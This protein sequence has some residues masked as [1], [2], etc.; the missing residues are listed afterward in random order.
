MQ[1]PELKHYLTLIELAKQEDLGGGDITSEAT[2]G[3]D[4]SGCGKLVFREAGVLCGM[5]VAA[6]AL[7]QYNEQLTMK[8]AQSDG[9][10]MPADAVAATIEGPLRS[11]LSAERVLLNFL[12][13]LSGIATRTAQFVEAVQ[14]TGATI[15]DTRKTTPGWRELEKYAVRCGGGSNHRQGL[16]DAVLIKDNHLAT[17]SSGTLKERLEAVLVRL[18]ERSVQPTFI[19]V[20]VDTLDQLAEVLEVK[21]VN[22]VLLDN[23]APA[24]L[25]EGIRLRDRICPDRKVELEASGGIALEA[26]RAIA[27]TG[28]DRISVGALT[29]SVRSLDIGLDV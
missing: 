11:L 29:H 12:Q 9:T 20:E 3:A 23:M 8:D 7:R 13:R 28:V 5:P 18:Q 19:E 1:A 17:L 10:I 22:I 6:E 27:E 16:Y 25:S 24:M 14:G 2:I 15:Y 26:V 21:G 4:E